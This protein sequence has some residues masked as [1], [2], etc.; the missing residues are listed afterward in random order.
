MQRQPDPAER[1]KH[2]RVPVGMPFRLMT[3]GREETFQLL[4][5]SESGA[6]IEASRPLHP[7]TRLKV[8]L[9]L[10][11]NRVGAPED[12]RVETTGVVVWSHRRGADSIYDLGVFFAEL[13]DSQRRLIRAFVAS[14]A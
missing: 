10:P 12:A 9:T 4:D 2:T 14:H 6:R 7:M 3:E 13:D 5:L 8:S 11:A 1:R